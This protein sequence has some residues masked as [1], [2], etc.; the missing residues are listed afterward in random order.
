MIHMKYLK[1]EYV[2]DH[3]RRGM[4]RET[5]AGGKNRDR[6]KRRSQPRR[7]NS[8]TLAWQKTRRV[9]ARIRKKT[10]SMKPEF[11]LLSATGDQ[12]R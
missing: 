5:E 11:I 3:Q 9:Y 8:D 7:L 10:Y 2:L 1:P 4:Q 6:A 12:V